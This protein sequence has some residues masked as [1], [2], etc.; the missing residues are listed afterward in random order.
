[1]GARAV[2]GGILQLH[3][4]EDGCL[5]K[6]T[7]LILA[8]PDVDRQ[9]FAQFVLPIIRQHGFRLTIYVSDED[10]A[11]SFAE[12]VLYRKPRLGSTYR[13]VYVRDGV[14]TI[15]ATRVGAPLWTFGHSLFLHSER[16]M[17]DLFYLICG[18]KAP[19]ER[20]GLQRVDNHWSFRR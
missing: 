19:R 13:G 5:S 7:N 3:G 6:I 4:S 10:L 16:V 18:N 17:Q 14:D 15:D 1:M 12:R 8:A 20:F 11:M 2:S 9:R